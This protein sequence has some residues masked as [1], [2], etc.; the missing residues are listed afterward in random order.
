MSIQS[1]E[2]KAE[3]LHRSQQTNSCCARVRDF[4]A[5]ACSGG[6]A[7]RGDPAVLSCLRRH[8]RNEVNIVYTV[9]RAAGTGAKQ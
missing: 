9:Q 7:S 3:N 1:I 8:R 5:L 2:R 6:S 4:V